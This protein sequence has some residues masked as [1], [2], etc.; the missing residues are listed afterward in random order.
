[1][2]ENDAED[3]LARGMPSQKRTTRKLAQGF[4]GKVLVAWK[5]GRGKKLI[6]H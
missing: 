2:R 4:G 6:S 3:S 1:M 5:S